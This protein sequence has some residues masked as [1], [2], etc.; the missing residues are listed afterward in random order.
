MFL[1]PNVCILGLVIQKNTA[2]VNAHR[3]VS[4]ISFFFCL[5]HFCALM[6]QIN[7]DD[8]DDDDDDSDENSP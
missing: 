5:F 3:P 7:D 2:S 6:K 8:D 4:F 1:V